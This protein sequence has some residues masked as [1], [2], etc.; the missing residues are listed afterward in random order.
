ML[1]S[2]DA[3]LSLTGDNLLA[4]QKSR[5]RVT[6]QQKRARSRPTRAQH[7]GTEFSAD[8]FFSDMTTPTANGNGVDAGGKK[9]ENSS[10]DA[11][12]MFVFIFEHNYTSK[13]F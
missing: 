6:Q 12:K 8:A 2:E 7:D 1:T 9:R 5:G 3:E 11:S 4:M 10:G 13:C